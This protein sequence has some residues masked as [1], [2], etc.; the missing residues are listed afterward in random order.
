MTNKCSE[1]V[2]KRCSD[3][4]HSFKGWLTVRYHHMK[5]V[6]KRRGHTP[7]K[8]TKSELSVWLKDNY[9][10]EVEE[11]F[12]IWKN[13]GYCQDRS[14]S[15]DRLDDSKGYSFDNIQLV[16]WETN[17]RKSH[18]A[19]YKPV[20]QRYLDGEI[21]DNYKSVTEASKITG[22]ARSN[23]AKAMSGDR[24]TCGGFLWEEEV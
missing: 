8:F 10:E 17:Y 2:L 6:S 7:P 23:I 20:I 9:R 19:M 4:Y 14:P 22:C 1:E 12:N 15:V 11:L 21:K 3:Y 13:S 24:K 18:V 5:S 16:D